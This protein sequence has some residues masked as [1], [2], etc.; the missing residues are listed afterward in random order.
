MEA[1]E[2]LKHTYNEYQRRDIK[3]FE[4]QIKSVIESIFAEINTTNIRKQFYKKRDLIFNMNDNESELPAKTAPI[5]VDKY[6]EEL[7][8]HVSQN[9]MNTLILA[10]AAKQQAKNNANM[11]GKRNRSEMGDNET[12]NNEDGNTEHLPQKRR[13]K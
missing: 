11:L 2:Y 13:K 8:D 10:N 5:Y 3:A 1:S 4:R 12:E 7:V 9:T 6:G